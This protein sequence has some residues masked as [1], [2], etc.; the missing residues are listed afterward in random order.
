MNA[1]VPAVFPLFVYGTLLD[2]TFTGHLLGHPVVP[3][4]A[5]L[6]GFDLV[7]LPGLPYPVVVEAPECEA[8]GR[9]YRRLLESDYQK[10]DAYEGV[11]ERLYRRV[12]A[13]AIVGEVKDREEPVF[14][15]VPTGQT[16]Q[17]YG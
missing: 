10:L 11:A 4:T 17:R 7:S 2:A 6:L 8:V 12:T 3:E 14:V 15:Y 1:I 16:L 5:R 9:V 13:K